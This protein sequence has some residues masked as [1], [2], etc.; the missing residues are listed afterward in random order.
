MKKPNIRSVVIDGDKCSYQV[1][2]QY[3]RYHLVITSVP[4]WG[5][6]MQDFTGCDYFRTSVKF[7][8]A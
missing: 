1:Q 4:R 6:W 3:Y 2:R 5:L 8:G 7:L